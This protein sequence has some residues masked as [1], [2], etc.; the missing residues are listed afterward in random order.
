MRMA[1]TSTTRRFAGLLL[2][3]PLLISA[4]GCS[5]DE[6]VSAGSSAS[7]S[8]PDAPDSS[9]TGTEPDGS[10]IEWS[11]DADNSRLQT[12]TL[13]V[14]IDHDDPSKGTLDLFLARHLAEPD[15]R[16]GS[17]LVNPGGPGFSG[18]SLAETPGST[19]SDELIE[20][21]DIV[22]W[23]PRGTGKSDLAIDCIDDYDRF[24]ASSDI[25][26]DNAAERDYI[27][28][29]AEEFATR[30]V[31][32]NTELLQHV[33]TNSSARDMDLIRQA[34][35]EETISY[36]G[37]SYGSELGATWVTL[38]PDTVRAAVLDGAADPTAGYV[39][40]GLQQSKGFEDSLTDFL[41]YCSGDSDCPFFNDG[42]SVEAFDEL[43]ARVDDDPIPT[44]PG[45]PDA[46]LQMAVVAVSLGMYGR[47]LWDWLGESLALAQ[48]GDGSGILEM[49]DAYFDRQP[50]GE[51]ANSLEA[52][53][54]IYCMDRTERLSV[55]E[56]DSTA[57][58]FTAV[59]P[60]VAPGTTGSYF[61]T[62]FPAPTD[63]RITITGRGAGPVLVMGTTG[64]AATPLSSTRAMAAA[65]EDGRLVIVD[66]AQHTGYRVNECSTDVIDQYLIDPVRNTPSNGTEC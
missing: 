57:D 63:P 48:N 37:F 47:S 13:T 17:L 50:S 16:I 25:T 32:K 38:F 5:S 39:E 14:P 1:S 43:M 7:N 8:T 51:W 62:F 6:G 64:D 36:F 29:L 59:A 65:L 11:T 31:E 41:D 58:D 30:C 10:P 24:Y 56:E 21:F 40:S 55:E 44:E 53:Q 42:R 22:A 12:G 46:N 27:V 3:G 54:T 33:G 66:A 34:L 19:Y 35:G 2:I 49:Y 20:R 18:T 9:A 61:C 45:R 60:R 4:L 28:E 15:L 26:P 52:F 23:D